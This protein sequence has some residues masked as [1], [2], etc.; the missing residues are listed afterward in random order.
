MRGYMHLEIRRVAELRRCGVAKN[1]RITNYD[2]RIT[3]YELRLVCLEFIRND[4]INVTVEE[5]EAGLPMAAY[6][7]SHQTG[8]SCKGEHRCGER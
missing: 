4:F 8:L 2:L 1:L 6:R 7:S 5:M 3:N